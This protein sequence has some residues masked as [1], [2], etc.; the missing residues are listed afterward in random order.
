MTRRP[1]WL[2]RRVLALSVLG[3]VVVL[4][5]GLSAAAVRA[6][7]LQEQRELAVAAAQDAADLA[8]ATA[9]EDAAA[10]AAEAELAAR[11]AMLATDAHDRLAAADAVLV[12]SAG[13]VADDVRI[14]LTA[15][16][17]AVRSRL[18]PGTVP[19]TAA[20]D[21]LTEAVGAM[22][23]ASAAVAEAQVAWQSEQAAAAEAAAAA[24]AEAA[25]EQPTLGGP[26]S[27]GA[28][29]DCGGP[30]SYEPPK[31]DGSPV[32]YTSTP[33]QSGDGSNGRV[34]A[35]RMSPLG[36][37][38]DSQ[39]NQQWLRSDAAD[40]LTALNA[41]FLAEFGE[42]IAVDLSYRSF[43]DQVEMRQY[44]GSIA[45]TPG[46]SNH[47]TGLAIDVWEW[48]AYAFGSDRYDWLVEHAP[49]H[50]WA[51]PAWARQDGSNPEYWHF[52]YVG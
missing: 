30:A 46:T 24:A 34:P 3:L 6:G 33:S 44:Y 17:D 16:M 2:T 40:A 4:A 48:Q 47:G 37:C 7:T 45:A 13:Q 21:E 20:A 15:T 25:T 10:K 23:A 41:A 35:G 14:A 12:A 26:P 31:N 39:G 49:D 8:A 36:W 29:P 5:G 19:T 32:F 9:A 52:E 43:E 18:D 42:N 50:G 51:A 22:V 27:T 38:Q 28:G 1:A 11:W